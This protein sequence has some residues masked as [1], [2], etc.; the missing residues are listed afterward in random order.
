[1]YDDI[2]LLQKTSKDL[3]D[4]KVKFDMIGQRLGKIEKDL[5]VIKADVEK[6][7]KAGPR[8]PEVVA[9][10][11][12]KEPLAV[13]RPPVKPA[14]PKDTYTT[15]KGFYYTIQKDD[16]LES[17]AKKYGVSTGELLSKNRLPVGVTLYPGQQ[18]FIPKAP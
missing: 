15:P 2:G 16:T 7:K 9:Q 5:L 8:R 12:E 3:S 18:I 1:M 6:L 14:V 4:A 11:T 17:I 13:T 10:P